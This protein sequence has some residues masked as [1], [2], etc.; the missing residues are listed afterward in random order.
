MSGAVFLSYASQDAAAARRICDALRAADVEVWFDQSEL[1]G[2]DAWDQK[3][4]KQIRECALLIPVISQTTQG[5]REAYFRL[6]WKLADERTHLMAKGT[7]FLLPVTID[8]TSDR[9]ALVPDSFLAVQWTKAPGGE[10]P[11]AFGARLKRLL[12]GGIVGRGLLTPPRGGET[13]R[14]GDPALQAMARSPRWVKPV[15][16][17]SAVMVVA[18][19]GYTLK[20]TLGR[21]ASGAVSQNAPTAIG[22]PPVL[23]EARQFAQKA[24]ALANRN[25]VTTEQLA[26]AAELCDRALALDATDGTVWATASIVDTM[27]VF[28]GFDHSEARRQKALRKAARAMALAPGSVE[29]R[30]ANAYALGYAG[31]PAMRVA[32]ITIAAGLVKERPDDRRLQI[33]YGTLLREARHYDEAAEVLERA[34]D[35]LSAGWNYFSAGR[36]ADA[37]RMA[38]RVLAQ[39]PASGGALLKAFVESIGFEDAAA[40]AAAV[41]LFTPTD[42]LEADPFRA[43]LVLAFYQRDPERMLRLVA[44]FPQ[45][46]LFVNGSAEPKRYYSG[47]AHEMAGRPEAARAEWSLALQQ[48]NQ[49]L[50]A[51]PNDPDMLAT[52]A[53]L[54]ACLGERE[55]AVRTL[56]LFDGVASASDN[57]DREQRI[58][59]RLGRNDEA[60]ARLETD[61]RAKKPGWRFEHF[62]ARF[63]P[64]WEALRSDPRLPALL[65]ETR[66]PEAKPFDD[67][68]PVAAPAADE[69][70]VAVLAFDNLSDDRA[71]EY[72]SDGI[73]EELLTVLQKIPG[74]RVAARTSAFSFKGRNA[75]AQE[76]GAKLGVANLVEGSVRR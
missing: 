37:R 28:T 41:E 64:R 75:T 29:A 76:I 32:A 42:L 60:L 39:G 55:A 18:G 68:Q 30:W 54:Q 45:D 49:R 13:A 59:L 48:V 17:T 35:D 62:E 7:P 6:E 20:R 22:S 58:L 31:T 69:K 11:A 72:F 15:L 2:G 71:N 36:M 8:E 4:R 65:R 50:A 53:L 57:S 5:R 24:D 3:I 70:S 56:A 38:D 12:G 23:S 52:Q 73:S 44:A 63:D 19:L 25:G 43:T 21:P 74:L 46:F 47:L 10:L 14:S 61:L 26:A 67:P 33:G 27:H 16:V 34:G 9:D 1:V 40:G 51:Q 66:W